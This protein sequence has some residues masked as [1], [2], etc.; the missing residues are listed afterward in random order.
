M[1]FK[2]YL[3]DHPERARAYGELKVALQENSPGMREYVAGK[4][5]F[6]LETIELP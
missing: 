3:I 2:D 1:V 6:V 5:D 4:Q